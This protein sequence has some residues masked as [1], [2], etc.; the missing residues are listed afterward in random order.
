MSILK[1]KK[2]TLIAPANE[3]N[4]LL[5]EFSR[6]G[7]YHLINMTEL[8]Q[9][10]KQLEITEKDDLNIKMNS[11]LECMEYVKKC[12]DKKQAQLKAQKDNTKVA[13]SLTATKKEITFD[14]LISFDK[15][16]N[17]LQNK[18]INRYLKYQEE[19]R[20]A[21]AEYAKLAQENKALEIYRNLDVPFS[22]IKSTKNTE[23]LLGIVYNLK[24]EILDALALEYPA[25]QFAKIGEKGANTALLVV[26]HVSQIDEI[27]ALL[28]K[29]NFSTCTFD[30]NKLP[31]NKIA[32]NNLQMEHLQVRRQLALDESCDL[33]EYLPDLK[34]LYDCYYFQ[35]QLCETDQA[36]C[37]TARTFILQTWFPADEETSTEQLLSDVLS[38]HY[39]EYADPTEDETPP[40][41]VVENKFI[42]PFTSITDMY[43]LPNYREIDPNPVVAVFYW[44]FMGLIMGDVGY[45]I[46]MTLITYLFVRFIKPSA[47]L[48]NLALIICY[49]GVATVIWG[50]LFGGWFAISDFA[51]PE[52]LIS[53]LYE[54]LQMILLCLVLGTVHL[55][56]GIMMSMLNKIKDGKIADALLDDLPWFTF[57][58]GLIALLFPVFGN[59]L[60][61]EADLSLLMTVGMIIMGVSLA[62]L[63]IFGGRKKK[64]IG[65]VFGGLGNVYNVINVV[66]DVL[67]YLRLF[68]LGLTTG[69]IGMVFNILGGMLFGNPFSAVFGVVVLIFGHVL[70]LAISLLGAYIHD[71]R[72]QHIE[73]FGKFYTGEG[74]PFIPLANLRKYTVIKN[75]K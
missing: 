19:I 22:K 43:S 6:C 74:K 15:K 23:M 11:V 59:L 53:P 65:K 55:M 41:V 51:I 31:V 25:V 57:D 39:S 5:A 64:G 29:Y 1:M 17:H 8:D 70:N 35:R 72:L 56:T 3:K 60:A 20:T 32:D 48:R 49:G 62:V 46:M 69:V 45:G 63:V 27:T 14:D 38:V 28:A 44:M 58:L 34:A 47:G 52:L 54:P 13:V 68:G 4:K 21:D 2:L 24:D 36:V 30:Y 18:C 67:S 42:Q 16:E 7:K 37:H 9:T 40:T 26:C 33:G 71:A 61:W 50:V 10:N 73:F 75:E 12:L 66:S